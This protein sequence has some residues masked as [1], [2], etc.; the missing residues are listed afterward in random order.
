[1]IRYAS[2]RLL[3]WIPTFLVASAMVFL[4][5]R[6]LP[7]DPLDTLYPGVMRG[8]LTPADEARIR[9]ELDLDRPVAVQ[10]VLWL[11]DVAHGRLG[12][13]VRYRVPVSDL[14][15]RRAPHTATLVGSS[16]ALAL[17]VAIPVGFLAATRRG[18][19][20]DWGASALALAGLSVP[21]FALGTV[22]ALVL[23]VWWRIVPT[24][25]DLRLP[26]VTLGIA[27]T[28]Y[29]VRYVRSGVLDELPKDYVRLAR[30]KGVSPP[31]VYLR[32]VL[33]N[34]IPDT[35]TVVAA[36]IG[37]GLG[38]AVI[39]EQIFNWP[40]LGLLMFEAV[41]SR[42]YAVVQALALLSAFVFSAVNLI[43][44][45]ARAAIDPRLRTSHA[46]KHS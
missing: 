6:L 31:T 29:L 28:G 13:S 39:V 19:A 34:A 12:D 44:D 16:L 41:T 9:A 22:L 11:D 40:G 1:M 46:A 5:I 4:V 45:L 35:L 3:I 23:G 38:G 24:V 36:S 15:R 20:V 25:G 7:G 21:P 42:D 27:I 33:P 26:T 32:H 43:A 10:Y 14:L 8:T 17:L 18:G 30:S 37:Y 2:I